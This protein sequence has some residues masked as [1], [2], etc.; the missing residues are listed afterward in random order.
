MKMPD[1]GSQ[2]CSKCKLL[3]TKSKSERFEEETLLNCLKFDGDKWTFHGVY[4]QFLNDLPDFRGDCIRFQT[5]LEHKLSRN[6][7]ICQQFNE[8]I[9]KRISAGY[10]VEYSK[11]EKEYPEIS[12]YKKVFS[13]L[14]YVLKPN[15]K[16]TSTRPV[17]NQSFANK[18]SNGK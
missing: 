15:S 5:K 1:V 9:E 18:E 6:L 13:P 16:T 8:S 2:H 3:L 4:N 14:N 11:L 12:Q 17:I 10:Y 7:A